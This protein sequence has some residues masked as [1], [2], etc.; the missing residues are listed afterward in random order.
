VCAI[1]VPPM[2]RPESDPWLLA[3][4]DLLAIVGSSGPP[5]PPRSPP[6]KH[7]VGGLSQVRVVW[8]GGQKEESEK[9]GQEEDLKV[10]QKLACIQIVGPSHEC[11]HCC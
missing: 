9:D 5:E 1:C 8:D 2:L 11:P 3:L 10:S 6:D 4:L 7:I